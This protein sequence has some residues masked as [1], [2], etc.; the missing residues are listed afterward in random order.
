MGGGK[1]NKTLHNRKIHP[2]YKRRLILKYCDEMLGAADPYKSKRSSNKWIPINRFIYDPKFRGWTKLKHF[3][4]A[5]EESK[6]RY[7]LEKREKEE[8]FV[9]LNADHPKYLEMRGE[10]AT[11]VDKKKSRDDFRE[12]RRSHSSS[13]YKR[14]SNFKPGT[15]A[16]KQDDRSADARQRNA[17]R[18]R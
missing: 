9:Q 8:Y 15:R 2:Q 1:K 13:G 6:G 14:S 12:L 4:K 7:V 17:S 18:H 3:V 16:K 11:F 5:F 10:E